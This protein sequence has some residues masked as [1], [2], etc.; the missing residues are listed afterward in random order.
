[1]SVAELTPHRC[2]CLWANVYIWM[3]VCQE[4]RLSQA[5]LV[6]FLPSGR[7]PESNLK[8]GRAVFVLPLLVFSFCGGWSRM[9][10]PCGG[11]T[12][13]RACKGTQSL[14]LLDA[15]KQRGEDPVPTSSSGTS[16]PHWS[17][18]LPWGPLRTD[19]DKSFKMYL[20]AMGK[21]CFDHSFNNKGA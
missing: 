19:G 17:H 1:M 8:Q 3:L 18:F 11:I 20:E 15:G 12:L 6:S 13:S 16:W 7:T 10:C 2:K 4:L 14:H 9:C 21:G 5:E